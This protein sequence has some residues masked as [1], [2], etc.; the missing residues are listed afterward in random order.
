MQTQP[1]FGFAALL[2]LVV[3][4]GL[5]LMADLS[6]AGGPPGAS[7]PTVQLA[8]EAPKLAAAQR[9]AGAVRIP[10]ITYD[11]A[12]NQSADAFLQ[13]HQYLAQQYPRAHQAMRREV[14]NQ[15]SLLYTWPGRDAKA[16]P[17]ILIAHQDVVPVAPGTEGQWRHPP[18]GGV[19]DDGY[20]WGRGAWDNKANLCAML[21]AVERLATQGYQPE[22]TVYIV[23]GH[24][25]EAGTQAGTQGA[26]KVAELLAARGVH[27]EFALDE[28]LLVTEG[29]VAGVGRPL[30]MIGVA[31]KGYLKLRL[32]ASGS[33]G[34]SSMPAPNSAITKLSAALQQL[35]AQPMPAQLTPTTREMLKVLA[36]EIGGIKGFAMSNDWLFGP[37]VMRQFENTPSGNAMLRTTAAATVLRAGNKEQVIPGQAEAWVNFRTLPQDKQQAVIEHVR[38]VVNQA[39]VDVQAAGLS[40]E[41]SPVA[42]TDSPG[43]QRIKSAITQTFADTLVMPGLMVAA[44][45]S[46]RFIHLA[47]N[48]Y[49][50]S[51]VRAR[52]A[53]LTRFH[54]SNERM[55]IDNYAEMV[56]FYG[57]VLGGN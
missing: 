19:I 17:I 20:V 3:G 18:F 41:A 36:P 16:K 54:G 2:A 44:T 13:L 40:W 8:A 57:R 31:E 42:Q 35:E 21:E 6:Q 32:R 9:L 7:P 38:S 48:V 55:S 25:E 15:Y 37:L 34:H 12:P 46:R 47:D 52:S 56:E 1:L 11:D 51:P 14:V 26:A 28:G 30:A 22:R 50:F 49:R 4:L 29:I 27:A 45:D 43:Y 53:D 33:P 24:D 5:T 10:T 23:S 39:D